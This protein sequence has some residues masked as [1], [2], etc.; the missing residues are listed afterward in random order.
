MGK[1]WPA[2]VEEVENPLWAGGPD[3]FVDVSAETGFN[4]MHDH[5]E[6]VYADFDRDGFAEIVTSRPEHPL[7]Y[8]DNASNDNHGFVLDFVGPGVNSEG[9]NAEVAIEAGGRPWMH[10]VFPAGGPGHNP[11]EV[12][13]GLG[14]IDQ[15]GRIEAG[16]PIDVRAEISAISTW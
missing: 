14:S 4:G 16:W 5:Y 2:L 6:M 1:S 3:G 10:E 8:L 7:R 11:P 15:I 12:Y 13:I 9:L